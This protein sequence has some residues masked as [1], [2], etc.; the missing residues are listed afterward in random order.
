MTLLT[1]GGTYDRMFGLDWQLLADSVL[2]LIAVFVLFAVMSCFLFNP[3]RKMLDARKKKIRDELDE[4]KNSMESARNM[5]AEYEAKLKDVDRE[6]EG[7]L[8]DA[9]QKALENGDRIVAQAREEA[10]RIMERAHAEALLEKE[11]L[12]DDVKREIVSVASLMAG[13]IAASSI[14]SEMQAQLIDETLKEMGEDTW[15]S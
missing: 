2:T 4:A 1:V 8:G 7:I 6:A 5:K 13:K 14:S 12:K 9:R 10:S 15:L 3:A 11:K